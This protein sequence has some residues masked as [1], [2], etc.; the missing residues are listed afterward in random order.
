MWG[1]K[2]KHV[3]VRGKSLTVAA[4]KDLKGLGGL[5]TIHVTLPLS[6]N[7]ASFCT[8]VAS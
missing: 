8:L 6:L 7:S 4:N 2:Y 5:R 1:E 3:K